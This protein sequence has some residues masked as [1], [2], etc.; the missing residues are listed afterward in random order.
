MAA[1][2]LAIADAVADELTGSVSSQPFEADRH[3]LPRFELAEMTELKVSVV[4]RSAV[5]VLESAPSK[6]A[7]NGC[8]LIRC[9]I[10]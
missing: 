10:R 9:C 7:R 5:V 3:Y 6:S 1:T 4:P 8:L 2:I